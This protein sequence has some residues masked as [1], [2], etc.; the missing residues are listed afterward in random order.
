LTND[1]VPRPR[2]VLFDFYGTLA[3]W[4]DSDLS[5]YMTVLAAHGYDLPPAVLNDYFARYDG[6]EHVEHSVDEQAY[7]AWVRQRLGDLTAACGVGRHDLDIVLDAL[8]ASDRGPMD[9]YPD[10]APALRA[11]RRAGLSI[12]VCSNWGWELDAFLRQVGLL[13]LVDVAVTSARAGAR[14]PHPRIYA[15]TAAALGVRPDEVV[16]VGDSWGPDVQGP[17]QA[18]MTAVHLWREDERAGQT[19]PDL[20]DGAHRINDLA[21]L[22]EIL[23]VS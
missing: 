17:R 11:L 9:A 22:L 16:F 14:K 2:A 3:R 13:T 18:G 20:G 15:H 8:R 12:G 4:R 21:G 10:A 7:E 6:I 23:R 5:N 1:G 19:A